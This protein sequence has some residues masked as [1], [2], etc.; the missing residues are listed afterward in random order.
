MCNT[1]YRDGVQK[2]VEL[3]DLVKRFT[4]KYSDVF[5]FVTSADGK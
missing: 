5:K 4:N 1:Q 2:A 3:I